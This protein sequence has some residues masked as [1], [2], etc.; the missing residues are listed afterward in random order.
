MS[1]AALY[2][3]DN[4]QLGYHYNHKRQHCRLQ[5][6][7]LMSNFEQLKVLLQAHCNNLTWAIILCK[8]SSKCNLYWNSLP[9]SILSLWY[10]CMGTQS[11]CL[12][13]YWIEES[14]IQWI[15]FAFKKC[16]RKH[17]QHLEWKLAALRELKTV[18]SSKYCSSMHFSYCQDQAIEW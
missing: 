3:L 6:L 7:D 14:L 15:L 4:N 17:Y 16:Q 18:R 11:N 9:L 8:P 13:P 12:H 2:K 1:L 5:L 10:Q